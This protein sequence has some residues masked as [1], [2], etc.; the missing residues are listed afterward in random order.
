MN[1]FGTFLD[2]MRGHENAKL[3]K[4]HELTIVAQAAEIA[5]NRRIIASKDVVIQALEETVQ[6]KDREIS[7][8]RE[9]VRFLELTQARLTHPTYP[10]NG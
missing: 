9:L 1:S 7:S 3:V 6:A 2:T 4:A 8:L 10:N 5:A